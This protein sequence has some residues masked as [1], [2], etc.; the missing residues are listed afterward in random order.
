MK[1]FTHILTVL[2]SG[3]F[4][5]VF[6]VW[7]F[8]GQTPDYSDSERRVL[9]SFPEFSFESFPAENLPRILSPTL[10]SVFLSGTASEV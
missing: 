4:V 10:P 3:L 8:T 2:L 1:K 7:C 6:S 5:L 9:K